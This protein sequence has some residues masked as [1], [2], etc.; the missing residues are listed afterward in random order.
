MET[1]FSHAWP[2]LSIPPP[3]TLASICSFSPPVC[4]ACDAFCVPW[5]TADNFM[6][7]ICCSDVQFLSV[8]I[9]SHSNLERREFISTN[10]KF[11]NHSDK[12]RSSEHLCCSQRRKK[13]CTSI[14][15]EGPHMQ[16]HGHNHISP[17][18]CHIRVLKSK[19]INIRN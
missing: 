6:W 5:F 16:S 9:T 1:F 10:T 19:L 13:I 8:L 18:Q 11:Q 3:P 17:F 7:N 2:Y 12:T 14:K 4:I 15:R